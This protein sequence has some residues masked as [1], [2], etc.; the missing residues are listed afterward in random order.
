MKISPKDL[1]QRTFKIRSE[2]QLGHDNKIFLMAHSW[3]FW[4]REKQSI[5]W[6]SRSWIE[7]YESQQLNLNETQILDRFYYSN[8][9]RSELDSWTMKFKTKFSYLPLE[10]TATIPSVPQRQ[11]V[12]ERPPPSYADSLRNSDN[13]LISEN[14]L[15]NSSDTQRLQRIP[16]KT[17][18]FALVMPPPTYSEIFLTPETLPERLTNGEWEKSSVWNRSVD[19]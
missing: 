16:V 11:L 13:C 3:F 8:K 2:K 14:A 4:V 1:T 10:A 7:L 6:N 19:K 15:T 5:R 12:L 17:K 9:N 18:R